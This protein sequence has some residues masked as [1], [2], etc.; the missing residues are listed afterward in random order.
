VARHLANL[1]LKVGV[2]T[3]TAAVAWARRMGLD[4]PA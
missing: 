1:Y 3:R 2:S 4:P